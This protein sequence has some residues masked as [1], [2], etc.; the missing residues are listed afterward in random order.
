M[1]KILLFFAML[2]ITTMATAQIK[3]T[4]AG[5]VGINVI[6]P[7]Y[8]LD[9]KGKIRFSLYGESWDNIFLDGDNQ[10]AAPQLYCKTEN[11]RI[12]TPDY[13]I[14]SIHTRYLNTTQL[15][16]T[17]SDERMKENTQPLGGTLQKLLKLESKRYNYKIDSESNN[18]SPEFEEMMTRETFGFI[19]QEL[20]Q[21]FPQ[22][23]FRPNVVNKY[24]SINY[25]GMIPVLLEA[26]KEQQYIIETLQ[27]KTE[28]LEEV[29]IK[30]CNIN[31]M[32]IDDNNIMQQIN[33]SDLTYNNVDI[34]KLY[35]NAPN[36][37]NEHTTIQCYI[38]QKIKKVELC[39]YNMQGIQQKC[40]PISER[41]TV[42]VQ[43]QAGQLAAGIYT[44]LLIGDDRASETKQ[45]IL[46]K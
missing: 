32:E 42:N 38:P 36:P 8:K 17:T 24:Y 33:F 25:L 23:V 14:S 20:E 35:Q 7:A 46:T 37:Y 10:W 22:L 28:Y 41:G 34:M 5:N 43:I 2:A 12:G 6:N 30:C 11:F 18:I 45:M 19:A 13:L 40:L 1:K 26:I 9:V 15:I 44:Y 21:V 16:T 29:L 3:I 27:Q 31:S 4:T 39:I